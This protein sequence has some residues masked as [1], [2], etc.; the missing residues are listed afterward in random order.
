MTNQL[1]VSSSEP[2]REQ[3]YGGRSS[4]LMGSVVDHIGEAS[5][6]KPAVIR[7]NDSGLE[8]SCESVLAAVDR[9]RLLRLAAYS[10]SRPFEC[11]IK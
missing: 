11:I 2:R 8:L 10:D 4:P 3:V 6:R 1:N 5:L 9:M 7:S